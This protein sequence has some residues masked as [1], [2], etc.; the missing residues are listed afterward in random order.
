MVQTGVVQIK[1]A[2]LRAVK[3]WHK[4]LEHL[5][6]NFPDLPALNELRHSLSHASWPKDA[7]FCKGARVEAW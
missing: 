5:Q 1:A 7:P 3:M 2:A 4:D 6:K